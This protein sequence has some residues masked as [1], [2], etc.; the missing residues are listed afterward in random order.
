MSKRREQYEHGLERLYHFLEILLN[1]STIPI[2]TEIEAEVH[3]IPELKR[4]PISITQ[5]DLTITQPD[6]T[7][8]SDTPYFFLVEEEYGHFGDL[9]P[10][11]LQIFILPHSL[12]ARKELDKFVITLIL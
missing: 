6:S 11:S 5:P 10:Q 1:E 2:K 4:I 7:L 12:S 9:L 3:T 8:N